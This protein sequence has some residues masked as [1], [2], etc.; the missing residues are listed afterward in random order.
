M[1]SLYAFISM[2]T[3][4]ESCTMHRK[5]R[6]WVGVYLHTAYKN[7]P[8]QDFGAKNGVGGCYAVSVYSP[9]YGTCKYIQ[10]LFGSHRQSK[11]SQ[12][13]FL[14]ILGPMCLTIAFALIWDSGQH[15]SNQIYAVWQSIQSSEDK[16][17]W[18]PVYTAQLKK[19][20][21]YVLCQLVHLK[22]SL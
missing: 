18:R 11:T 6:N 16:E 8:M 10:L 2:C 21:Q 1:H 3:C 5:S 19:K 15:V 13:T 4:I 20:W 14:M 22:T 17:Q 12:S 7:E 9:L